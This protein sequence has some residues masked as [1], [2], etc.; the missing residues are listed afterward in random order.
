MEISVKIHSIGQTQ[1]ITETFS[2]REFIVETQE[3]YKQYLTLQVIKD[4]CNVL[5]N[6]KKGDE[7]EV[8]I[9]CKGRLWTNKE[10]VEVAFNTLEC[11][12]IIKQVSEFKDEIPVNLE[13][14]EQDDS[15]L[16]F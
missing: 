15:G 1:Q 16:P 4:K 3:E 10:G 13:N 6:F 11:W 9:N 2:K 8:S 5:D 14:I 7:V 12:K